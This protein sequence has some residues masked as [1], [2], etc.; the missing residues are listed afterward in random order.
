[1]SIQKFKSDHAQGVAKWK[2][3]YQSHRKVTALEYAN[4]PSLNTTVILKILYNGTI[5]FKKVEKM[6]EKKIAGLIE[7]M[8]GNGCSIDFKEQLDSARHHFLKGDYNPGINKYGH[9]SRIFPH[10]SIPILAELYDQFK[11]LPIKDRYSLYQSR[12]YEF[13][14][15]SNDKILDI[16]SGNVPFQFATHLADVSLSNDELGR[17]GVPFTS[18][19]GKSIHECDIEKLPFENKEFDFVYCSHVL[20]HVRE[21]E[22]A[23]SELMRIAKRGYIETPKREKDLWLNTTEVSNHLWYIDKIGNK[24]VFNEYTQDQRNGLHNDVL[25]KMHV[26]PQTEREKAF[27]ALIYLKAD[28]LNTMLM[29]NESFNVEVNRITN[30]INRPKVFHLN[31]LPNLENSQHNDQSDGDKLKYYYEKLWKDKLGDQNWVNNDGKGRVSEC[32]E[33]LKKSGILKKNSNLLDIGCGK[34]TLGIFI[35]NVDI[36]LYGIDISLHAVTEAEKAYRKAKCVNLNTENIPY[37]NHYF[38]TAVMLDV[39]EHVIDPAKVVNEVFRVLKPGG[40]FILSTP[41]I[42]FEGHLKYMVNSRRFPKTSCDNFPYDGGHFHFFTYRDIFDLLNKIG[43]TSQP[44]GPLC[45]RFDYEFKESMVWVLAKKEG[46][47]Q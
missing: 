2:S 26:N 28:F 24:L 44:I 9:L 34:G 25:M 20:E 4:T 36:T 32:A 5:I 17:A 37:E 8:N 11:N 14:L 10:L 46:T 43:F 29:W 7:T 38:D 39:I 45:K 33:F 35:K 47:E 3:F 31:A 40:Y 21:P 15:N 12:F 16:G 41:N 27:S 19:D 30:K 42:L 22:K 13:N 23:C 18:V 1:M 6:N